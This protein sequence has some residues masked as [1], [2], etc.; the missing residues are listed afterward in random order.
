MDC[1]SPGSSVHGISQ[2]RLLEWVAISGDLSNPGIE[3]MSPAWQVDSLPLSLLG[4]CP[5]YLIT[6]SASRLTL[7]M[8]T[9]GDN[10]RLLQQDSEGHSELPSIKLKSSSGIC[11]P[12]G[13]CKACTGAGWWSRLQGDSFF[14]SAK[15]DVDYCPCF[16]GL[17]PSNLFQQ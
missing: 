16:F 4:S 6:G 2:A 9:S 5:F 8:G 3:P 17:F 15:L 12:Q 14:P 13:R 7:K 10:S 11:G 1:S